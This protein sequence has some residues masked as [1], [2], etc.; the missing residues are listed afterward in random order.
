MCYSTSTSKHLL[1][2][3]L[4]ALGLVL[5]ALRVSCTDTL[6]ASPRLSTNPSGDN[7]SC[8]QPSPA[9]NKLSLAGLACGPSH[10][11]QDPPLGIFPSS[12]EFGADMPPLAS[13][14]RHV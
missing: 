2:E 13:F 3:V 11:G 6:K 5:S 9:H 7:D 4:T 8:D 10:T 12:K 1:L 14:P